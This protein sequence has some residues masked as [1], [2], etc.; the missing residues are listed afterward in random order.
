LLNYLT[1]QLSGKRSPCNSTP[2]SYNLVRSNDL[3][4]DRFTI[5]LFI[6]TNPLS[7]LKQKAGPLCLPN[8]ELLVYALACVA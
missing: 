2:K 5:M 6:V 1:A 7:E 3:C 8:L 4:G